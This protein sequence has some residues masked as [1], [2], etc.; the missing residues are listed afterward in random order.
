MKILV[1]AISSLLLT[2][3]TSFAPSSFLSSQYSSNHNVIGTSSSPLSIERTEMT[4]ATTTSLSSSV[5]LSGECVLTPEGYGFSSSAERVITQAKR[6]NNGYYKAQGNQKVIDV[7]GGI[8]SGAEDVSLVYE[9]NEL[10][11]IFTETDYL[12]VSIY[13][14]IFAFVLCGSYSIGSNKICKMKP[15][16]LIFLLC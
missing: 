15:S 6:G 11:G 5:G 9:G 10:L 2:P 16:T 3:A 14:C 12:E 7:M 4:T 8:T 1:V 13:L